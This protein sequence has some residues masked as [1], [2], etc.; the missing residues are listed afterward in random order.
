MTLKKIQQRTFT[1]S[2]NLYAITDA[3]IGAKDHDKEKFNKL[4]A[5]IK[6]DPNGYCFFNGDNFEL[7]PPGYYISQEGQEVSVDEQIEGFVDLLKELGDKVIFIR[8]GNHEER[9]NTLCGIDITKRIAKEVKLPQ[10]GMGMEMFRLIMKKD[11]Q[12]KEIKIVSSHGEGGNS[13][14]ILDRMQ[15]SFP[16]ADLYFTGHTH[17]LMINEGYCSIDTTG[18]YEQFKNL[19]LVVGGSF[20]GWADYAREKNKRPLQTG[21]YVFE[22]SFDGVSLKGR[23]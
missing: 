23:F 14:S 15:L 12:S 2:F 18:E 17:E 11:T 16:G 6:K 10:L 1:S 22:V 20:S 21:C 19:L 5:T 8:T 7:I 3:H 9:A 13:K 4:I